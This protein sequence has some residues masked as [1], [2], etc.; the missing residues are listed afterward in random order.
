MLTAP[1]RLGRMGLGRLAPV[2]IDADLSVAVS[3][4]AATLNGGGSIE[5][6]ATAVTVTYASTSTSARFSHDVVIGQRYRL[7]WEQSGTTAGQSGFGTTSGGSQYR[8]PMAPVQGFIF[9]FTA[10]A[11]TLWI[12]FQR[13]AAGTTTFSNIRITPIA[14]VA[15]ADITPSLISKAGWTLTAGVTVDQTTGAITIPATGTSLSARQG[16]LS[17]LTQGTLYRLRWVNNSNTTMALLG[18]SN[19]NQTMK[20][21]GSSDPVGSRTYEFTPQGTQTWVQFQRTTNGTAVVSDI[22]FQQAI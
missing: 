8:P 4:A 19:G 22:E 3:P 12:S 20:T 11:T 5:A 18:I 21:S 14:E 17:G 7:T 15:W 9:D 13:A 2:G 16:I 6:T 10:T 1:G